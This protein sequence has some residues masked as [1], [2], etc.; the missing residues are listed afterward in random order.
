MV[1]FELEADGV[2]ELKERGTFFED[3]SLSL[4]PFE[5]DLADLDPLL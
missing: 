2:V 4:G 1:A 5:V 3:V